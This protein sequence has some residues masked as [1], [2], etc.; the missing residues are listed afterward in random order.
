MVRDRLYGGAGNDFFQ[1][2]DPDYGNGN[3]DEAQ[4]WHPG[5][6]YYNV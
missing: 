5:D 6:E 2:D 4:D 1:I 3:W